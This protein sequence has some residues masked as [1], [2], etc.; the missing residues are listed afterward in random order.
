MSDTREGQA[1]LDS[2]EQRRREIDVRIEQLRARRVEI[3]LRGRR[4]STPDEA[5]A[6]EQAALDAHRHALQA[7]S[8]LAGNH[9]RAVAAHEHAAAVLERYGDTGR[10]GFHRRA[11]EQTRASARHHAAEAEGH[12]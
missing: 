9:E 3:R 10:A 5:E 4:G 7:H 6:A 8:R 2:I 11:A 1:Y 12:T